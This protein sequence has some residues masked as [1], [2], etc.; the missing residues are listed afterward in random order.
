MTNIKNILGNRYRLGNT[1][2]QSI[3]M[4]TNTEASLAGDAAAAAELGADL[5][6]DGALYFLVAG[7]MDIIH[8]YHD[9]NEGFAALLGHLAVGV[10]VVLAGAAAALLASSLAWPAVVVVFAGIIIGGAIS[11]GLH[12][13]DEK[14]HYISIFSCESPTFILRENST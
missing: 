1:K 8:F 6:K 11:Y 9:K 13:L 14:Y 7:V 4:A 10:P 3:R 2:I 12:Q 5:L